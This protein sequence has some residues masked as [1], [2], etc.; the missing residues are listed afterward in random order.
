[1]SSAAA[2][3]SPGGAQ[4]AALVLA[5][6]PL[7]TR[8]MPWTV[9]IDG[10][11]G[12]GKSELAGALVPL[13]SARTGL[14][15]QLLRLDEVYPGWLGLR[16]A[17]EA[18]ERMLLRPRRQGRPGRARGWDWELGRAAAWRRLDPRL[19]LVVEG[20]GALSGGSR[21]LAD[22]AVWLEAPARL[23]RERALRR[24][25]AAYEPYWELWA[26]QE[27]AF[28]AAHAPRRLADVV[29]DTAG[30]SPRLRMLHARAF[31]SSTAGE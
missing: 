21:R 19:P 20:C 2:E 29:L 4:Q 12:T 10:R 17:A 31:G 11:S 28:I 30:P 15:V 1:M 14:P 5:A 27:D 9:L 18:L 3:P 8:R 6:L 13:A 24:D 26:A 7:L 22:A 23:R 16:A 25:G